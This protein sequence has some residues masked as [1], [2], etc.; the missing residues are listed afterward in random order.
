MPREIQITFDAH[1]PHEL[2]AW[3]AERLGIEVET[4]SELVEDLVRQGVLTDDMIVRI[5]GETH[6]ADAVAARDPSGSLPRL[7]FQRVPEPKTAKNRIHFDV[8]VVPEQL[9]DEV[10]DW[11]AAGATFVEFGSHPGHRWAIMRDPE[12][13]EFCLH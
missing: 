5:G 3:W 6:F 7:Y 11:T 4:N 12:G 1:D 8:R 13:N 10:A 2:A 9:D